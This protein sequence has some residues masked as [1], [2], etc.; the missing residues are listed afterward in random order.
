MEEK[1]FDEAMHALVLTKADEPHK[2]ERFPSVEE[3]EDLARLLKYAMAMTELAGEVARAVQETVARYAY[4]KFDKRFAERW[5]D[6][7]TDLAGSQAF[8]LYAG[9]SRHLDRAHIRKLCTRF[10]KLL[11]RLRSE[12][13]QEFGR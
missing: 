13:S 11:E 4:L 3:V 9:P 1:A 8:D 12:D 6:A 2:A 5:K 10:G 7:V